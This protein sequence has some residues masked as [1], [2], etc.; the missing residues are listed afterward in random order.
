MT[1]IREV[2][3]EDLST[4]VVYL[5]WPWLKQFIDIPRRR[6]RC[7]IQCAVS[8][9]RINLDLIGEEIFALYAKAD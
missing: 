9:Q 7:A 3:Q 6:H 1:H 2:Q 4:G 5:Y 8:D